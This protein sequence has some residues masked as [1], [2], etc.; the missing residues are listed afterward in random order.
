MDLAS[1]SAKDCHGAVQQTMLV[2]LDRLRTALTLG[3]SVN[4]QNDKNQVVEV[5]ANL[6]AALQ[7]ILRKMKAEEIET[8]GDAVMT[9][10]LQLLSTA[11]SHHGVQEDAI[12]AVSSFI[13]VSGVK[14]VKYLS[15]FVPFLLAGLRAVEFP[16]VS[17]KKLLNLYLS[18]SATPLVHWSP[19]LT[20][21]FI[22]I[23]LPHSLFFISIGLPLS[24]VH[25]PSVSLPLWFSSCLWVTLSLPVSLR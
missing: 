6:C 18:L 23:G 22:S 4:T 12:M 17:H 19:S 7:V 2:I 3:A 1:H 14:F 24:L 20:F 9:A 8:I 25:S 5:Q 16:Q 13:D 11:G 21:F 10:L 15:A